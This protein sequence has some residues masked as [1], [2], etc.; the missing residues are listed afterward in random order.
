[1]KNIKN[2]TTEIPAHRSIEQI[3]RLLAEAGATGVAMNYKKDG[4]GQIES[5]FFKIMIEKKEMPFKLPARPEKAYNALFENVRYSDQHE[6]SRRKR[7]L[8]VAW[9]IVKDW[10]E[11]QLTFIKLKQADAGEVLL[12]YL[13]VDGEN[14][15]YEVHKKTQFTNL[16]PS[17][18]KT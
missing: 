15:L 16:L 17:G 12:P 3:Q 18:K 10:L 8:N 14:T 7:A 1:M 2:Y 5:L 9:R 6:E 4:S 13:L 11:I